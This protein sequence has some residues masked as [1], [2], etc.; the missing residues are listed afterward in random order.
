MS[1]RLL[2]YDPLTGIRTFHDF[3]H[4]TNQTIITQVQDVDAILN[5]NKAMA[6]DTSYK[7]K[8]IKEDWYHFATVPMLVLQQ[9]MEKYNISIF[10]NDDLPKFEKILASNEYRY[11]RTVDR[12]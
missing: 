9:I 12:I 11:L 7:Q 2:D 4:S 6:N 1:K 3:D 5:I 10:N 8:G